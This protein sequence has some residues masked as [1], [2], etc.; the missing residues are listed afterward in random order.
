MRELKIKYSVNL[1]KEHQIN[2]K[3]LPL[4]KDAICHTGRMLKSNLNEWDLSVCRITAKPSIIAV[5]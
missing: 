4:A 5:D 3:P 1:K 2:K